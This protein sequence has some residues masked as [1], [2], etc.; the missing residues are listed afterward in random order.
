M[1]A[2][3]A[4]FIWSIDDR[5][6]ILGVDDAWLEFALQNNAPHLTRQAV[7]LH[8]IWDFISGMETRHLYEILFRKVRDSQAPIRAPFR[9]DS[10]ENRRFMT[11]EIRPLPQRALEFQC[12]LIR[13]EPRGTSVRL[14]SSP[15]SSR[16]IY[17]CSWCNKAQESDGSWM[18]L[19]AAIRSLRL[20]EETYPYRISHGLCPACFE[21]VSRLVK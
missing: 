9:C 11:M 20:L 18:E 14:C 15:N 2:A 7:L 13:L 16:L 4:E 10:P 3:P 8:P 12:T 17:F 19:D 1:N 5:D 21:S 6:R